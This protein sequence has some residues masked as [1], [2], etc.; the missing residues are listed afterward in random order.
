VGVTQIFVGIF[1]IVSVAVSVAAI[2]RVVKTPGL[3][4]KPL[5]I[6]GSAFGFVGVATP[7]SSP[8][9]SIWSSGYRSQ[10]S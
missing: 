8:E 7:W 10:S 1:A 3:G 4:Y 9:I 5:W 6:I 2:W